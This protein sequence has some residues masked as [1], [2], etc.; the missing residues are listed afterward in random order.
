MRKMAITGFGLVLVM[1]LVLAVLF[2][3]NFRTVVVS[4]PSMEPTFKSG[5][6]LLANRT[7]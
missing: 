5:D 6:H 1:V 4:G 7:Y 3:A 2:Y